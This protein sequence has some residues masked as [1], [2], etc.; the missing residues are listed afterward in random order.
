MSAIIG[1]ERS[2]ASR[3]ASR[4]SISRPAFLVGRHSAR[5]ACAAC[6]ICPWPQRDPIAAGH[7]YRR[8]ARLGRV[9][10]GQRGLSVFALLLPGIDAVHERPPDPAIPAADH[11]GPTRI[12]V[13]PKAAGGSVPSEP[14]PD[15]QVTRSG[16][17]QAMATTSHLKLADRRQSLRRGLHHQAESAVS[18]PRQ[19]WLPPDLSHLLGPADG[20]AARALWAGSGEGYPPLPARRSSSSLHMP[21]DGNT[22]GYRE[23]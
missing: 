18:G 1:E 15:R 10:C 19:G 12:T 14:R 7:G 16:V 13:L 8:S 20:S 4:P 23:G 21:A 3:D 9:R 5:L 17:V 6:S 11:P 2:H 22:L